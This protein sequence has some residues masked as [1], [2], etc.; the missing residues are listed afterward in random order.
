MDGARLRGLVPERAGAVVIGAGQGGLSTSFHLARCGIEHVVLERGTVADSWMN[1]RWDS[2]CL[3]TPNWTIRLPGWKC[4]GADP[5]GFMPRDEFVG[6]MRDWAAGFGAPIRTGVEAKRVRPSGAV[7]PRFIVETSAGDI[8]ADS[9]VVATATYQTPKVPGISSGLPD[10]V[11]QLHAEDYKNPGQLPEGAALVIG[12]GQTGCQIV[13]DLLRSGR[14]VHFSA[15]RAGRL[16]R[17]YRGRD[18][19]EWQAEMGTLDRTPDQLGNPAERFRGDPHVTGRD[20][21]A[22]VG[23]WNFHSRGVHLLGRAESVDGDLLTLDGSL[24]ES[25]AH[26][27]RF[28]AEIRDS[29]DA[30]IKETGQSAPPAEAD[31]QDADWPERAPV[32]SARTISLERSLIRTVI[33]ATG[34]GYDFS[35]IKFPVLDGSGYPE[36]PNGATRVPGLYFCGLNWMTWR[37]S[38]IL[39]G[40]GEDARAVADRI[41]REGR[42]PAEPLPMETA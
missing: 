5:G 31:P 39:Y 15:G 17:R 2:F 19:L 20:G 25:I 32:P 24:A 7:D 18:C 13:E 9:V 36:A 30:H 8:A 6:R 34:F 41:A 35:W 22:S 26:A 28:A 21:G 14:T 38:G 3:V 27:D 12:S 4:L 16:P 23:F 42:I 1:R 29:I 10:S 40:V 37:K 33:W 11:L